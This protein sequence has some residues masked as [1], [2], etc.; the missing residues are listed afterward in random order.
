[1][2]VKACPGRFPKFFDGA[3]CFG[4][5]HGLVVFSYLDHSLLKLSP[6]VYLR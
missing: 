6:Q 4:E 3:R 5:S 1:M 2:P